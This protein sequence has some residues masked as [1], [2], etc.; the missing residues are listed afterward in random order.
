MTSSVQVNSLILSYR[1]YPSASLCPLLPKQNMLKKTHSQLPLWLAV[2]LC[3]VLSPLTQA[4]LFLMQC[5][6]KSENLNNLL[7]SDLCNL[8]APNTQWVY[9]KADWVM[10]DAAASRCCGSASGS[11][12]FS[13]GPERFIELKQNIGKDKVL[14]FI[15][16]ID[17]GHVT[18]NVRVS[19]ESFSSSKN[20]SVELIFYDDKGNPL[21]AGPLLVDN[22]SFFSQTYL[23]FDVP[24]S[25]RSFDVIV[26]SLSSSTTCYDGFVVYLEESYLD[27]E[28][29]NMYEN[30]S[31]ISF[32]LSIA[33]IIIIPP[34]I[35][36]FGRNNVPFPIPIN[37]L[38]RRKDNR[39]AIIL[40][41]MVAQLIF[42][43]AIHIVNGSNN[44]QSMFSIDPTVAKYTKG[45]FLILE[46][47]LKGLMLYP[48]FLC[49]EQ[50]HKLIGSIFGLIVS[51]TIFAQYFTQ[52]MVN[53][54]MLIGLRK[55]IEI[56]ALIPVVAFNLILIVY[57][58]ACVFAAKVPRTQEA[59][60]AQ[61]SDTLYVKDLLLK[62][63]MEFK[64]DR[65]PPGFFETIFHPTRY[66]SYRKY[67]RSL[68][69]Y[70][71]I[72]DMI[73]F[74][75]VTI[76]LIILQLMI[77]AVVTL[78][79]IIRSVGA[80]TLSSLINLASSLG[81]PMTDEL[82]TASQVLTSMNAS[83]YLAV[84]LGGFGIIF[85]VSGIKY[86]FQRDIVQLRLGNYGLF[87]NRRKNSVNM[88]HYLAFYGSALGNAFFASLV[89]IFQLF[90]IFTLISAM[91][92][93]P[94][95]RDKVVRWLLLSALVPFFISWATAK[96]VSLITSILFI[97]SG[98][99]FWLKRRTVFMHWS[100]LAIFV[101]IPG[102]I[103][104]WF[105]R[106]V[107]AFFTI[108][109]FSS[110][111]DR[112]VLHTN[113][114]S[115]D[116]GYN[117]YLGFLLAEHYYY[118]P[119]NMVFVCL[120]LNIPYDHE[121]PIISDSFQWRKLVRTP[122]IFLEKYEKGEDMKSVTVITNVL[123]NRRKI[124]RN[125]WHLAYT[126]LNNPKVRDLRRHVEESKSDSDSDSD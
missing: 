117:S 76:T 20:S 43:S 95:V 54:Y 71:E 107:K 9:N 56:I 57:F 2:L 102:G 19:I 82:G 52:V 59:V 29:I 97:V 113:L 16:A 10:V 46:V 63:K 64:A 89:V 35:L 44:L 66:F 99:K 37:L 33:Y 39:I 119:I 26:T 104:G 93:I 90:L 17:K 15:K 114:R 60:L 13:T 12:F 45:I 23:P 86:R 3:V 78:Y 22:N 48:L 115:N 27:N 68:V 1:S 50:S 77:F 79:N 49:Y 109:L 38:K 121:S 5:Q 4:D 94:Y 34:I 105:G 7:A 28:K 106:M 124:A 83:T 40:F 81:G 69:R 80:C 58:L 6:A 31:T 91:I 62:K 73:H 36:I 85:F 120:M 18:A 101:H 42:V 112:S 125:R 24:A 53:Y 32:I 61:S 70:I 14:P 25:A 96:I 21:E 118:N 116:G 55:V 126:L 122:S 8:D 98:T 72:P 65:A 87:H 123:D 11:Q 51:V 88:T 75:L 111:V 47:I 92:L 84:I 41:G 74:T 67:K 100:F 30:I 110:R 103:T 108:F